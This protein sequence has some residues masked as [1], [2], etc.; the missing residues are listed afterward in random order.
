MY[1]VRDVYWCRKRV[2]EKRQN[3][4]NFL[5][6]RADTTEYIYMQNV[7]TFNKIEVCM[8]ANC[9]WPKAP[10]QIYCATVTIS[11]EIV[12]F[13]LLSLKANT[14]AAFNRA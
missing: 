13:M 8:V 2:I 7:Y 10:K 12:Q 3:I 5:D 1:S 9:L 14:A 4:L 11:I 6:G